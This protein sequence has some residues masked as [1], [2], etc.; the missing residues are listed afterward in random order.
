MLIQNEFSR[1]TFDQKSLQQ[2]VKWRT[3]L[4]VFVFVSEMFRDELHSLRCSV[5]LRRQKCVGQ[6][7][8][9]PQSG[10]VMRN[11]VQR[12]PVVLVVLKKT[13]RNFIFSAA[14]VP[15]E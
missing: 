2:V 3:D 4:N 14:D 9:S 8:V 6:I 10:T 13:R 12:T 1:L 5:R 15:D 11:V 7:R